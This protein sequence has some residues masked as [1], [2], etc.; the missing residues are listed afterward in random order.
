MNTL[1]TIHFSLP[2]SSGRLPEAGCCF[3]TS[4]DSEAVTDES[5]TSVTSSDVLD[6]GRAIDGFTGPS[7]VAPVSVE[8]FSR[9][10]LGNAGSGF[11][12]SGFS[13]SVALL[14][15]PDVTGSITFRSASFDF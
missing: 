13:C 10:S 9:S 8:L 7:Q 6:D 12:C 1:T 2:S 15:L 4:R 14:T 11:S 5:P 3:L